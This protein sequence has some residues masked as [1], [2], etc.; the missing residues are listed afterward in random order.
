MKNKKIYYHILNVDL[1]I[2][3][4][5]ALILISV[6]FIGVLFR[7]FLNSP[8]VWGEEV[9][10]ACIV[11]VLFFGSSAAVRTKGHAVVDVFLDLLGETPRKIVNW[12]IYFII[13]AV[14]S[15]LFING[16]KFIAQ[17]IAMHRYTD[18][19]KIPNWI[20]YSSMP[21]SCFL[22]IVNYTGMQF[23]PHI[24]SAINEEEGN[25]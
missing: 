21:T 18:A 1:Y 17:M 16:C 8:L 20:I 5:A 2:A 19:L 25:K 11:W 23:A 15:Y 10:L 7:Y 9:Q 12:I 22:M 14:L 24:F 4:L 3:I 6:A 13:I